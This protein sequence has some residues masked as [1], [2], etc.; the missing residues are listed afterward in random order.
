MWA[1]CKKELRQFFS[2]L[3]G[4]IAIIAFL[5]LNGLLLF[6]FP[7]TDILAFGYATLDKFLTSPQSDVPGT[8]MP[9]AGIK[10]QQRVNDLWAYISQFDASANIKK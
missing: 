3:T 4:Y 8:K 10:D 6:V 9:F 1:V 2:S 5:S 7:D